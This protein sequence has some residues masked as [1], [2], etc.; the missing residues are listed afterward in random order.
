MPLQF[1]A[2]LRSN[3]K[4]AAQHQAAYPLPGRYSLSLTMR[5]A[6]EKLVRREDLSEDEASSVMETIAAGA[7]SEAETAAFLALLAAKGETASEVTAL[8]S[9]M[10]RHAVKVSLDPSSSKILDIVGTGGDGHNTINISTSAAL[11]AASCGALVAK[12]GSRSVTSKSGSSDVLQRLG[13]ALLGPEHIAKCISEAGIAFMFAPNFH[14]AMSHVVPVR[15]ALKIRTVFNI[16]GP[17]LNPAGARFAMLGV[18]SPD[19]LDVYAETVFNLGVEHALIVH[20]CGLDELAAVGV[21]EAR[22]VTREGI[23]KTS[24]DPQAMGIAKCTIQDLE[25]GEPEDNARI[26]RELFAGGEKAKGPVADTIALNAGAALY[27]YGTCASVEDGYK[28]ALA[29]IQS[30]DVLAT[31]D[32]FAETSTRLSEEPPAKA[33]KVEESS[34]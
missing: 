30:G 5:A 3:S 7:A 14:P 26:I 20:C 13:I 18:Y 12:H 8:A 28:M 9:V 25:G 10:R 29:K 19:L 22:E 6:L 2:S 4:L 21:A 17:L 27:V 24:I 32:K 31:L 33:A 16:L 15:K 23:T 34:A 1:T 11:V